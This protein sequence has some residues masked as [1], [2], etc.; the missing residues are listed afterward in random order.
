MHN[1]LDIQ[2]ALNESRTRLSHPLNLATC[3]CVLHNFTY[4][5]L[6]VKCTRDLNERCLR[7]HFRESH[8]L[9]CILSHSQ[10]NDR[11]TNMLTS[12]FTNARVSRFLIFWVVTSA[13]LAS[14]TDTKYYIH[15]EVVPHL[16]VYG[17]FWRLLTWQ[18]S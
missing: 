15:I 16:W 4:L 11:P 9:P 1:K 6:E 8:P 13:L 18:V 12:G 10:N 5:F 14:L 7:P 3:N 2:T 17:Q